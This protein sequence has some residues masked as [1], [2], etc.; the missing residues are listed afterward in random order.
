VTVTSVFGARLAAGA[1]AGAGTDLL[2]VQGTEAGGH[3]SSF[4][5]LSA[6]RIPPFV[7]PG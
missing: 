1:G 3:Q 7:A 4:A 5:D 2:I 6:N